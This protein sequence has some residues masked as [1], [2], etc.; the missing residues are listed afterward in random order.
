LGP[1]RADEFI[2]TPNATSAAPVVMD[3]PVLRNGG[4]NFTVWLRHN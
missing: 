4:Q 3:A 2:D 1:W